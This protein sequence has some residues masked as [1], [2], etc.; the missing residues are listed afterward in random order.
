[1]PKASRA[2]AAEDMGV[3]DDVEEVETKLGEFVVC[4]DLSSEDGDAGMEEWEQARKHGVLPCPY[5]HWGYVVK[6]KKGFRFADHEEIY[7]AGDAY[8]APPGHLPLSF[9]GGETV[10]FKPA[11]P[12]SDGEG[13]GA[14]GRRATPSSAQ[15]GINESVEL[16]FGLLAATKLVPDDRLAPARGRA[17]E[18]GSPGAA[19]VEEGLASSEGIA[20]MLAAQHR[21]PLVDLALNGVD[22]EAAKLLPLHLLERVTAIPYAFENDVVH[23]AVARSRRTASRLSGRLPA[24]EVSV[25]VELAAGTGQRP[26]HHP[27]GAIGAEA[28][29]P[30]RD[31]AAA[32]D[33]RPLEPDGQRRPERVDLAGTEKVCGGR[34]RDRVE[35][36]GDRERVPGDAEPP[37][38]IGDAPGMKRPHRD[39]RG[40]RPVGARRC[41]AIDECPHSHPD[42]DREHGD[43]CDPK[44]VMD[45]VVRRRGRKSGTRRSHGACHPNHLPLSQQRRR[46]APGGRSGVVR[47]TGR[48]R[49]TRTVVLK[50]VRPSLGLSLFPADA[51]RQPPSRE[52]GFAN[53]FVMAEAYDPQ[54]TDGSHAAP[55]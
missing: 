15:V 37:L 47:V 30:R 48:V 26:L 38:E 55:A 22:E 32:G 44:P 42:E 14:G 31:I 10:E 24:G 49:P 9:P 53:R 12:P 43:G 39:R 16:V 7:E 36:P 13:A 5:P 35:H 40:G 20:R 33:R 46:R 51:G 27:R 11:A 4:F 52:P 6:G 28:C 23:V 34:L 2:T 41:Q 19:L 18:A 54:L 8:Y 17:L 50:L 21:V 29:V 1:M 3:S 25:R 45:V